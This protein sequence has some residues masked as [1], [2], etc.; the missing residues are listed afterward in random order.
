MKQL[1]AFILLSGLICW[2]MFAPMYKHVAIMRQAL[3][4]QEVDYLLEV[5]TNGDHGY[6]DDVMVEE[7]RLR[8][9][10]H[11]F[12]RDE[13]VFE[14]AT[15]SGVPAIDPG[16]PVLKGTGIWLRI[17][18]PYQSLFAID[19]II[20]VSGPEQGAYMSASGMKMSEYVPEE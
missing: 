13:L 7:S 12:D 20:G 4:Q 14:V 5:G 6:I 1:L 10:T 2:L 15:D 17:R 18:Y 16:A 9:T 3:L 19:R 8:L 11:G